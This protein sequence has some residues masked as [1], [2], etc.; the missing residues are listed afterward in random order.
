MERLPPDPGVGPFAAL[1]GVQRRAMADGAA[2]FELTLGPAHL[3]PYGVAHGG[4][5]YALVDYA[6]GAALVTRLEPGE[7]CATLEV[8]IQYLAPVAAGALRAEARV[9]E[10]TRRIGVLDARAWGDGDRLVAL[11]TGTFYIHPGPPGA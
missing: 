2:T 1:L 7:R 9:V 10:R 8:K 3:N 4:V 11:A 6:M 5:V